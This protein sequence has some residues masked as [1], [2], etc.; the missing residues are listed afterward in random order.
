MFVPVDR[1][2]SGTPTLEN[3]ND[4]KTGQVFPL[5]LVGFQGR[6][7][8]ARPSFCDT[9]AKLLQPLTQSPVVLGLW[10]QAEPL[11]QPLKPSSDRPHDFS[12]VS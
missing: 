8:L 9:L 7:S 3:L 1:V 6:Q 10:P 12:I 4:R 5:A 2:C 11:L